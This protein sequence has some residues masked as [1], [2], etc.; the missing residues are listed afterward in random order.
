MIKL[1][2]LEGLY[3][4]SIIDKLKATVIEQGKKDFL[5][6]R[7]KIPSGVNCRPENVAAS[8]KER[9]SGIFKEFSNIMV[10]YFSKENVIGVKMTRDRT[11]MGVPIQNM[12]NDLK[13]K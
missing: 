8:L 1:T 3:R 11:R 6:K 9:L 2:E 12:L 13:K 4:E 7:Y 10:E 5:E